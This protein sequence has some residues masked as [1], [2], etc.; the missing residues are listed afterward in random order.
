VRDRV[1]RIAMWMCG[2]SRRWGSMVA[3]YWTSWPSSAQVLDQPV[4]QRREVQRV[5]RRPLVV[6]PLRAGGRAVSADLAIAVAG[7]GDEHRRPVGRAVRRG[8]GLADR[9]PLADASAR[10]LP[11]RPG[12]ARVGPS[13]DRL[14]SPGHL[15]VSARLVNIRKAHVPN[16]RNGTPGTGVAFTR[17]GSISL[18]REL[19][20]FPRS[21]GRASSA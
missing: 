10:P 19:S 4:E 5:P 8:V 17:R 1:P 15:L 14:I 13:G 20:K 11:A 2:A 18:P 6:I 3:K 21:F 7:Q 16:A 12:R 9:A